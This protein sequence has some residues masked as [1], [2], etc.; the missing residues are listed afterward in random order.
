FDNGVSAGDKNTLYFTA[1]PNDEQHGL[2]G[3]ITA[4]P[5][6]TNPVSAT[7]SATGTLSIIGSPSNDTVFVGLDRTQEH[8]NVV[9]GGQKIGSFAAVDVATIQFSG[10]AGNDQITVSPAISATT[11]LDGGAGNDFLNGGSGSNILL[12]GPGAD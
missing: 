7:L 11:V 10:F 9:A 3:K 12:G 5:N 8:I 6:G 2:F 1:G 4:N